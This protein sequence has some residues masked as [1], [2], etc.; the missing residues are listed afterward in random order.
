MPQ[1]PCDSIRLK[2]KHISES[3][4]FGNRVFFPQYSQVFAKW[5]TKSVA[6]DAI[7]LHWL[8][9]NLLILGIC[10]TSSVFGQAWTGAVSE[11]WW[12]TILDFTSTFE[13]WRWWTAVEKE[14]WV[15]SEETFQWFYLYFAQMVLI[16]GD[17]SSQ[18]PDSILN[19]F[20]C[21]FINDLLPIRRSKVGCC[22]QLVCSK[23][24]TITPKMSSPLVVSSQLSWS[25]HQYGS[26][27]TRYIK[28]SQNV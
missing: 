8:T 13:W 9:S 6:D 12:V 1:K 10:Q 2:H 25:L 17:K 23:C 18:P 14:K 26:T 22:W 16:F 28:F 3:R 15:L 21:C 11:V 19:L 27:H 7:K 4:V 24:P 20:F 5:L